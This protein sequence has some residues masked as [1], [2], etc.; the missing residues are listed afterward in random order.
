M[1]NRGCIH[2]RARPHRLR[3]VMLRPLQVRGLEALSDRLAVLADDE[4]T[5]DIIL[6]GEFSRLQVCCGRVLI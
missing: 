2:V 1:D 5:T 4:D 3:P 6:V